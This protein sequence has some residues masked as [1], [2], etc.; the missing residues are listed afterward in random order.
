[1]ANYPFRHGIAAR[2]LVGVVICCVIGGCTAGAAATK[3][4]EDTAQAKARAEASAEA[5]TKASAE[6]RAKAMKKL[7]PAEIMA[8]ADQAARG[9]DYERA[10]GLYN[11]AIEVKPSAELWYRVAWI[12][13]HL[14][15]KQ[16]AADSYLMTLQYD[17]NHAQANEEL[18]LLYLENKKRDK[19]GVHLQRAVEADP[20]QWRSHNALGVLADTS[21]DYAAAIGHYQA[22]LAVKPDSAQVL[23]NLGYSHY[24]AGNL[25]EAEQSYEQALVWEPGNRAVR[26]NMGLLYAR[27]GNYE[28]AVEIMGAAMNKAKAHNDVG[29]VAF[30]NGDMEAAEQLL[31]EAIRLS[32]SYY[33]T[34]HQNLERM[35]RAQ[36]DEAQQITQKETADKARAVAAR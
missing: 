35:H 29:Y 36:A 7:S 10:V 19:A 23:N 25:D 12:Y 9:G 33:E 16:L 15:K 21:H 26:V 3:T 14:G 22:A 34:A 17:P 27:R 18:G 31:G 4:A 30:Q 6:A 5:S 20:R 28:R 13:D 1:M 2:L 24:L 8:A 11:L 32:P